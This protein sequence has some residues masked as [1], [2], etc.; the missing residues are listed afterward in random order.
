VGVVVLLASW[1]VIG[2]AGF[3]DYPHLLRRFDE[4][5]G[6]DSYTTYVV[7][8]DLGLPSPVSRGLWL[9]LG[10]ALVAG[11]VLLA[12]SGDERTSFIV[13]IAASLALTP[14]VWLHY[15]A[16]LLV[17]VA[18]AQPRLGP[19]WFLPL[20]LV[21][22]PGSGHPSPFDTAWALAV[23]AT[24]VAWATWTSSAEVRRVRAKPPALL[25][26]SRA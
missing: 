23:V 11:V 22:T 17:V 19:L 7:G 9:A 24:T 20:A 10:L 6:E 14:I 25:E 18:L 16:L 12:Q 4:L 21:I 26:G 2:F 5:V 3:V 15:F 1:S 8:L 13:A